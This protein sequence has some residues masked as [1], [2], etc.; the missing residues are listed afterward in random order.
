ME[1]VYVG[2]DV[3]KGR[4]DI[5]VLPAGEAFTVPRD[6]ESVAS[7]VERLKA[8]SP[9]LIV[10]EATGGFETIVAAT[11]GQAGLPV[12]A[13][14]PRQI[15]AF[16]R[17][18][19]Q[20]AKTDALDAAVIA[21]FAERIRPELRPL[22]DEQTRILSELVARRRQLV[23][24]MTAERNRR[25][26]LSKKSLVKA[27]DRH[28]AMLQKDL[29]AIEEEIDTT[30]RGTPIWHEREELMTSVPGVGPTLA[31]TILADVPEIG[32][33]D[34]KQIAA[35]IGVAPL[36]WD[37]GAYRGRRITWGGR[38][39]VRT[40]LYM[41]ALVASHHNPVL[42]SFYQRLLRAGKAKKLALVAVMRKLLTI[43]N[44][45]VRDQTPW[46]NA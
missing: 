34:R 2:I 40:A 13:V 30:V 9:A 43:L 10:L 8:L 14:N 20:L 27:L 15:R 3:A 46:Q 41:A 29:S 33:L 12:A 16:A 28:L 5:H 22:P 45:I 42:K 38:A 37:S 21:M 31:R 19:G 18:V 25:A 26:R 17:S 7:L 1:P 11:L 6:G 36:N 44:A 35:L 39:K 32:T 24:M 23:E 4:L